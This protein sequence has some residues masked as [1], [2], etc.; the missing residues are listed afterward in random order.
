MRVLLIG[1]N[2]INFICF[3]VTPYGMNAQKMESRY[4]LLLAD[5]I[6]LSK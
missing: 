2:V 4:L 3:I 1:M 5:W 6:V